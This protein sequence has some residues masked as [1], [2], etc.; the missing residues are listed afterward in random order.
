MAAIA[1]AISGIIGGLGN[2]GLGIYNAKN[3]EKWNQKNYELQQQALAE[4]KAMN[5]YQKWFSQNAVAVRAKDLQNAGLSKTLA[6]G[7]SAQAPNLQQVGAAQRQYT[8]INE[9]LGSQV[10]DTVFS[11]MQNSANLSIS[12]AEAE[13]KKAEVLK[14]IQSIYESMANEKNKNADT[15]LKSLEWN[16]KNGAKAL[17]DEL[18]LPYGFTVGNP[19]QLGQAMLF[20][21]GK[22]SQ[23]DK[24]SN[25]DP[26]KAGNILQKPLSPQEQAKNR[27][28]VIDAIKWMLFGGEDIKKNYG[29]DYYR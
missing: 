18:G 23:K 9:Q 12:Y 22:Y 4:N 27:Q 19:Y 26:S 2:V 17:Y 10:L 21:A 1:E 29:R 16:I 15:K 24:Q 25:Y 5:E 11:S 28:N 6:A 7:S 14:E 20:S 3:A 13:K 8:P